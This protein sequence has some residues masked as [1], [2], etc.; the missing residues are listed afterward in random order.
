MYRSRWVKIKSFQQLT[1][2][3]F[4]DW[5]LN[6]LIYYKS[7]SDHRWPTDNLEYKSNLLLSGKVPRSAPFIDS[8]S[9]QN[10][11]KLRAGSSLPSHQWHT[12]NLLRV[13][14]LISKRLGNEA[15]YSKINHG[16]IFSLV[17][18]FCQFY[19]VYLER[20]YLVHMCMPE[21]KSVFKVRVSSKV[22]LF[23]IIL[24]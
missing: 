1:M 19:D 14:P 9:K 24:N 5:E 6:N 11:G 18:P 15:E 2:L 10:T 12:N 13:N 7:T 23:K 3:A 4:K 22:F 16:N 17:F 20:V 21:Q 8:K